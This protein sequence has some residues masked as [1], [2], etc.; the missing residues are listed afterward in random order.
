[1]TATVLRGGDFHPDMPLHMVWLATDAC[2]ARCMHCSS[3]SAK[4]SPDEL[5]TDEVFALIDQ[6]AAVG[7]VDF[8]ISGGEPLIRRDVFRIIDHAKSRGMSVGL[9]SNGAKLPE[10]KAERLASFGLDRLQLSLDGPAEAH[11]RLRRWPG[12]F[13]RVLKSVETADQA[14]LR[15]HICCTINRLN[16]DQLEAFTAFL[17]TLPVKRVNYSRFVPTGRGTDLLDISDRKW[18]KVIERLAGLRREYRGRLEIVSHLAQQ[19]LV[20]DELEAMPAFI[21]CQAGRGQGCITANGSVLPCVLLPIP[22]GNVRDAAFETIWRTAPLIRELQDRSNLEGRCGG[23]ALRG[24]C[25]G[26]RAV[27][28]AKAG[29]VFADDPRCW[30]APKLAEVPGGE[31]HA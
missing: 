23:C 8:G 25:G 21:G 1:M 5:S 13:E 6:L 31:C 22:V 9:A 16:V 30:I 3:N 2:T 14:G 24:R 27:A 26:C 29:R 10:E 7:V 19:V 15:V 28:F 11:D 17:S 20:D 4:R 18:R 12:L